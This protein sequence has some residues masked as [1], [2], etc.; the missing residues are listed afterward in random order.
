VGIVS[1]G[2]SAN[3]TIDN[4]VITDR[5]EAPEQ[6]GETAPETG[7]G[8]V[9]TLPAVLMVMSVVAIIALPHCRRRNEQ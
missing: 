3:F 9:R 8:F 7:D 6:G 5:E 2:S 1:Q 4:L